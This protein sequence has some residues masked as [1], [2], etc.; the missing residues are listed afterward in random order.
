MSTNGAD[1]SIPALKMVAV[2]KPTETSAM[3]AVPRRADVLSVAHDVLRRRGSGRIIAFAGARGDV[4]V[5][6]REYRGFMAEAER[7][8]GRS[9]Y[10][11][12]GVALALNREAWQ[13]LISEH[14]DAQR[15]GD[16]RETAPALREP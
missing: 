8:L 2:A 14:A 15:H 7:Q 4:R 5:L 3:L 9:G 16:R 12:T 11:L 10:R 1:N 6:L 13:D